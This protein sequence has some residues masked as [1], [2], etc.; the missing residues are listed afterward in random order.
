MVW[1]EEASTM[2]DDELR[3]D[4][5]NMAYQPEWRGICR[6]ELANRQFAKTTIPKCAAQEKR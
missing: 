2:T 3:E 4:S 5:K 1:V 6:Q